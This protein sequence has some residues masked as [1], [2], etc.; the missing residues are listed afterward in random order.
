MLE[1]MLR[2]SDGQ[3]VFWR[4]QTL[5]WVAAS[6]F[7]LCVRTLM[8]ADVTT[9][10]LMGLILEPTAVAFTCSVHRLY[11]RLDEPG[12]AELRR[13]AWMVGFATF[14]ALV[15]A[16]LAGLALQA[17][18]ATTSSGPTLQ[19]A[20]IPFGYYFLIFLGWSLAYFWL[21]A[22][23]AA[24]RERERAA[25][26]DA[27]TLRA[28]L[29]RLRL[30]L[31]PHLIFN[32]LNGIAAEVPERPDVACDMLHDL[33][34]YLRASLDHARQ[35][36]CSVADEVDNLRTFLSIQQARF[37]ERLVCEVD[38]AVD[39]LESS[40]PSFALQ[41]L[42]ENAIK[43]GRC[44]PSE[45]LSIDV[46]V[47]GRADALCVEVRNSGRLHPDWA[48]RGSPGVGLTNLLRRLHVHYPERHRFRL[49][50]QE[51]WVVAELSFTGV[52]CSA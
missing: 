19:W 43:H 45:P 41:L 1:N 16:A 14:A 48:K 7:G 44:Q 27:A 51:S 46:R 38:V 6:L 4:G 17:I 5:F 49:R 21:W 3:P 11:R 42:V 31:D 30:Q 13:I 22:S 29:D 8:Y 20:V 10:L 24:Q 28:E 12:T 36:L 2:P 23:V 37:G 35:P 39:A 40:L 15:Q 34:D 52:A 32:A 25:V 18:A 9:A 33:A 50:Q 26:A 47:A